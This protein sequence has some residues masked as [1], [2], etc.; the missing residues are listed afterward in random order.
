[1]TAPA[2]GSFTPTCVWF[3]FRDRVFKTL[4]DT[5]ADVSCIDQ[6]LV[7][8]FELLVTPL[9]GTIKLAQAGAT[10]DRIGVTEQLSITAIFAP[11][12]STIAYTGSSLFS[13]WNLS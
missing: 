9:K 7:T 1:M 3:S 5:G 6:G 10:A 4:L 12:E 11:V 2:N 13:V 8:E